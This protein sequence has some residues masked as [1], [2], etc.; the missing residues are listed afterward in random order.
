MRYVKAKAKKEA[1]EK[2]YRIYM[3]DG[4][5]MIAAN[6]GKYFGGTM[7]KNRFYD[8]IKE[9]PVETRTSNEIIDGIRQKLQRME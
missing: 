5:R 3:S 9:T 4:I 1:E 2:A 8:L 7:P 6:T